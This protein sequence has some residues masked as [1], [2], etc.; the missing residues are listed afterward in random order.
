MSDI[1]ALL[2]KL[3]AATEGTRDLDLEVLNALG[4]KHT[5]YWRDRREEIITCD[6]YGLDAIGNPVCSL[7]KFTTSI[8]DA[9]SII[10]DEFYWLLGKGK[11]SGS[12]TSLCEDDPPYGVQI[13]QTD[14]RA[15]DVIAEAKS[16]SAPIAICIAALRARPPIGEVDPILT[17]EWKAGFAAARHQAANLVGHFIYDEIGI[18]DDAD[19]MEELATR[20]ADKVRAMQDNGTVPD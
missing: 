8:D 12:T 6:R 20:C 1:Y 10:P 9:L 11:T 7:E 18:A 5:W 2:V 19:R 4:H 15:D 17:D 3:Q 14:G 13:L 16:V